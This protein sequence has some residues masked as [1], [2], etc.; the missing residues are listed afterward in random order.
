S[1]VVWCHGGKMAGRIGCGS[2]RAASSACRI[3][4]VDCRTQGCAEHAFLDAGPLGL[5]RLCE[6]RPDFPLLVRPAVIWDRSHGKTDAGIAAVC[7]AATRLLASGTFCET[8][9][10]FSVD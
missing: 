5:Y 10:P 7:V 2:F 9:D 1:L 4:S 3:G 6:D 8:A